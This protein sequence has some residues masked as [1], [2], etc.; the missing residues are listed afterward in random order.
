MKEKL[1]VAMSGG[2]D[3]SA[4]AYMLSNEGYEVG[5]VMMR[6][7]PEELEEDSSFKSSRQDAERVCALLDIPFYLLD[8]RDTFKKGGYR[9]IRRRVPARQDTKSM[10]KLQQVPEIR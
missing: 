8:L 4:V 7:L 5:G 1:L 3:S 6:L 10:C 2:I 9:P